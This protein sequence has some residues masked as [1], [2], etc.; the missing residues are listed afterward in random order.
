MFLFLI[1]AGAI[2]LLLGETSEALLLSA[3]A[4]ASVV[5]TIVQEFRSERVLQAL[6]DLTARAWGTGWRSSITESAM[7][8]AQKK[9][10]TPPCICGW[11]T[12]TTNATAGSLTEWS[13]ATSCKDAQS[14]C[15]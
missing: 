13:T 10:W 4:T 15:C 12:E 9:S 11:P 8:G 2:Y 3:F 1:G 5:I 6:R 14:D 7:S